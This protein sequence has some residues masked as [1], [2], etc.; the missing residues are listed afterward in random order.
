MK[1]ARVHQ[2]MIDNAVSDY[3]A[4]RAF[5]IRLDGLPL[6]LLVIVGKPEA[7][8]F[9][10][11]MRAMMVA[12]FTDLNDKDMKKHMKSLH[13]ILKHGSYATA[14]TYG[15]GR[16]QVVRL[17]DEPTTPSAIGYLVHELLHV[18]NDFSEY[19]GYKHEYENDEPACYLID[20]LTTYVLCVMEAL[21]GKGNCFNIK[22]TGNRNS[23]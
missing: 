9:M 12:R 4:Y 17:T 6:D 21:R 23:Q 13:R 16:L 7:D 22:D 1:Q 14:E 11:K 8:T 18:V 10:E 3:K 19:I 5:T 15:C 2:Y 20:A